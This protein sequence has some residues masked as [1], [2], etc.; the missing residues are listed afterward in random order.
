MSAQKAARIAF[1]GAGGHSTTSLYPNIPQIP[2]F[3]LVAVCDLSEERAAYVARQYGAPAWFTDVEK[4]IAE[5]QPE[6]ICVCGPGE[7]H[8]Q[9]GVQVLRHGIPLFTEKPPGLSLADARELADTAA[10]NGTW[11]MVAFMKRFAPANVVAKEYMGTEA[12][13]ELST[14]TVIHTSGPYNDMRQMLF[15]NGIHMLDLARF[16]GG[17]VVEV[18]AH[19]HSGR[20]QAVSATMRFANGGVG[21]LN[22]NSAFPS[23]ADCFEQTYISGSGAAILIDASRATE[24]MSPG[25][26]FAEGGGLELYGWSNR[27]YVSGNMA[28]WTSGGHYTRGYW[29][30]LN[31]F[32]KAVLGQVEPG[33]TLREGVETVALIEAILESIG[34]GAPVAL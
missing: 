27:Y 13:G 32:A 23:W 4:M 21:Q 33:P 14:I 29:G 34:S 12:F 18:F 28:G 31:Q 15:F 8:H 26:R 9:V 11:G 3:E 22:M 30:E 6:G 25:G 10:D 19:G 24:V 2:E 16:L 1:I 7:M 5:V 17:D 20:A